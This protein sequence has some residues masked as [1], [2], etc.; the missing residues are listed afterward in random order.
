MMAPDTGEA[1]GACECRGGGEKSGVRR[2]GGQED[3]MDSGAE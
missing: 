1:C 2:R 3:A